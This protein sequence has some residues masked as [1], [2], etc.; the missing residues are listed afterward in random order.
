MSS[1]AD[2]RTG[3]YGGRKNVI[4]DSAHYFEFDSLLLLNTRSQ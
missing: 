3:K 1:G 4:S 2:E